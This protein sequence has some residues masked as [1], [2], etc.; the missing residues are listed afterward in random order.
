MGYEFKDRTSLEAFRQHWQEMRHNENMRLTFSSF[1]A[2]IVAAVF[3][4]I[5]QRGQGCYIALFIVLALLSLL[6]LVLCVR[7]W[8]SI[9]QHGIKRG[10]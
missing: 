9:E 4:F 6:G 7:I 8:Q 2:L 3:A 5:S 1:Y 10:H